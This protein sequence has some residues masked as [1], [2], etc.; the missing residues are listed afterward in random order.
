MAKMVGV[1]IDDNNDDLF[2]KLFE[3]LSKLSNE[4]VTFSVGGRGVVVDGV[5]GDTPCSIVA[6]KY[7]N[8]S[9]FLDSESGNSDVPTW[10]MVD[11]DLVVIRYLLT[12]CMGEG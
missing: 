2:V 4:L 6:D 9:F 7:D 8:S 3:S 5:R 10:Y 1:V 11:K 12:D